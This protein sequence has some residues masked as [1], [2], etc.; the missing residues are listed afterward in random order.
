MTELEKLQQQINKLKDRDNKRKAIKKKYFTSDK[1]KLAR[2]RA[3]KN[4][5]QKLR[6]IKLEKIEQKKISFNL[7][8]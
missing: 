6:N 1:G 2:S 3:M 4:Y 8:I 7:N 5:R